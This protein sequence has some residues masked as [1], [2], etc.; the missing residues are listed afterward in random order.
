MLDGMLGS[1][2]ELLVG[3]SIWLL[4]HSY[5]WLLVPQLLWLLLPMVLKHRHQ[6]KQPNLQLPIV[7][8]PKIQPVK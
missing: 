6:T 2:D 8:P 7:V 3:S 4:D 5:F 1:L